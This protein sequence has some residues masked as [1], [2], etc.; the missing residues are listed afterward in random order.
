MYGGEPFLEIA[1]NSILFVRINYR[2][3]PVAEIF[4]GSLEPLDFLPE[5]HF[6]VV[7]EWLMRASWI[8]SQH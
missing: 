5:K 1:N 7:E 6:K 4:T 3:L 8:R 2:V